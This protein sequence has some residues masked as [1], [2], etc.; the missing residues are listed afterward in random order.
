MV[1]FEHEIF[2]V[3]YFI[4]EEFECADDLGDSGSGDVSLF[5]EMEDI[6]SQVVVGQFPDGAREGAREVSDDVFVE[7]DR[8]RAVLTDAE[9][10][11]DVFSEVG[12]ASVG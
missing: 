7:F 11:R 2:A 10:T 6:L 8:V 12:E 9:L 4:V 1:E 3:E 5:D